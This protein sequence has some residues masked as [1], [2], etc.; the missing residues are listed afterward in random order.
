M[1]ASPTVDAV[2]VQERAASFTRRSIKTASKLVGLKLAL[3]MVDLTTLGW[4]RSRVTQLL[5]QLEDAGLVTSESEKGGR[6]KMYRLRG[7]DGG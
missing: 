5:K 7:S 2:M 3:S 1:R 4:T 6:K